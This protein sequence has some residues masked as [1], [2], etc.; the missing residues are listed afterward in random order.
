MPDRATRCFL[1]LLIDSLQIPLF[2]L[3]DC[4]AYGINIA[5]NYRYGARRTTNFNDEQIRF[6]EMMWI[7]MWPSEVEKIFNE[8][9]DIRIQSVM[10]ITDREIS[11][12]KKLATRSELQG[13]QW[14]REINN[15]L[16]SG[17]KVEIEALYDAR[18]YRF[19]IDHY[20]RYK[21]DNEIWF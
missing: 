1:R 7:G 16:T 4:D 9:T 8:G 12:L 11:L 20:L 18:G 19:L 10:Q 17:L 2:G 5:V 21:L 13:T 14:Q 15:M 6:Q 3:F